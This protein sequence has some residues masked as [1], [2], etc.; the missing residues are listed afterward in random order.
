MI[1][2][3]SIVY[4]LY[5]YGSMAVV[6]LVC[7]PF[8]LA[9][10][11]W[12]MIAPRLWVRSGIWALRWIVG[13]RLVI[14]GAENIPAG[15][16]LIASKHQAMLDTMTPFLVM[17]APAIVLK[18]E[19][20]SMPVFGWFA[21]RTGMIAIDRDG[22]ASAL[23]GMLREARARAEEGRPVVIYPEGTRQEIGARPDYKPGV[24]ALY[25]DL[26][27]P[28]VPVAVSTGLV[29][30]ANGL[31]RRPGT[32]VV[33]FLPPIPP[34]LSRTDFMRE[35]EARIETATNALIAAARA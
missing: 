26:N 29:W 28:C 35:L 32:A 3:R 22:H 5:L 11:E 17:R 4:V 9:K 10:R 8:A 19:L 20:L 14:E 34:G 12:A 16:V 25:R 30:S 15:R 31:I 24:A 13:A 6:G 21:K 7:L 27:A 1:L 23:K 18:K 33:R 2:L